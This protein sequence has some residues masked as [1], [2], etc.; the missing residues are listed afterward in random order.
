MCGDPDVSPLYEGDMEESVPGRGILYYTE[1]I[2]QLSRT[3]HG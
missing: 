3:C 1:S 2:V